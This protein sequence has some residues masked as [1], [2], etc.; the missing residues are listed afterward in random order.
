MRQMLDY[1]RENR[2]EIVQAI[3]ESIEFQKSNTGRI[4][5]RGSYDVPA[6]PAPHPGEAPPPDEPPEGVLDP[7]PCGYVLT[8]E[9]Y[10]ARS[11]TGAA[12]RQSGWRRTASRSSGAGRATGSCR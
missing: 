1:Y 9:Q 3:K 10:T 7:P 4:V 8:D 5:F 12:R 11:R 6:F 2:P